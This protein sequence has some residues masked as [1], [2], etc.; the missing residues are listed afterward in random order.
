M[1][2]VEAYISAAIP[3]YIPLAIRRAHMVS[4]FLFF[5]A[6]VLETVL[7]HIG[8]SFWWLPNVPVH[9]L[10]HEKVN[11]N[12]G[13]LGI[14]DWLHGTNGK[15]TLRMD[16]RLSEKGRAGERKSDLYKIK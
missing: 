11:C 1:H 16:L 8:Y 14:M 10:H 6:A 9:D 2:P 4:Y 12:F 15:P 5:F 3:I 7:D 13:V